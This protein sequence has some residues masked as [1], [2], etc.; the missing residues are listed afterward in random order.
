M[1]RQPYVKICGITSLEDA[2]FA[3]GCLTDRIG[4]IFT[5]KSRRWIEPAKAGAIIQWLSGVE[6]VGVF[7]DQSLDEVLE[8]ARKTGI[9]HI[10]LHGEESPAYCQAL[11]DELGGSAGLI[12]TISVTPDADAQSLQAVVDA[13]TGCVQDYLFDTKFP[14][15]ATAPI[16]FQGSED[17]G[18]ASRH[19]APVER[20]GIDSR[21]TAPVERPGVDSRHTAPAD[22]PLGGTGV[23]FDWSILHS[24]S[25]PRPWWIGGG[26]NRDTLA[27]AWAQVRPTGFDLSSGVEA[28]PSRQPGVKDYPMMMEFFDA[29]EMIRDSN[30]D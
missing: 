12:K 24:L 10:Q 5:P 25:I 6:S 18:V 20:P 28:D 29:L 19:T 26:I 7:Q 14:A 11:V 21:H 8:I 2:R 1:N 3:A 9:H 15:P 23:P 17:A 4:F 30:P 13:Y 27:S 22:G 16:P